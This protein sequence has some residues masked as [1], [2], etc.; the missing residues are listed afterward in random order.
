MRLLILDGHGSHLTPDFLLYAVEHNIVV[1]TLPA[2]TSHVLQPLDVGLFASLQ[3]Y[4]SDEL[5]KL[6]SHGLD[7]INRAEFFRSVS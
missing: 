7:S 3:R 1:L 2:H 4:Y 5:D 6:T